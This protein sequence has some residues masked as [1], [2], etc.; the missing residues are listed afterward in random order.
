[1]A[2]DTFAGD[3]RAYAYAGIISAGPWI[4]SILCLAFLW[5][6]SYP[7]LAI[8]PQ[9]LFRVTVV[10][11]FAYSLITTGAIQLV[12][13]RF[14]ADRLYLKQK[15]IMLPTYV[16]LLLV[17]VG[18][19]GLSA[20]IFY[21]NVD[22]SLSFKIAS[23]ML[24]VA[25]SCIWQTM[26]FLSA[27]HD[28]MAIAWAFF[29][30]AV[31]SFFGALV[32]GKYWG[33]EGHLFGFTLGQIAIVVLLMYRV[34]YEFDSPVTCRF[35]FIRQIPKYYQLLLMGIFYYT[36]IWID[37]I[38]YWYSPSGDPIH[39]LFYSHYP[40][41]SC[42]FVAFLTIIPGLAHFLVDME[43]NF[44]EAYKGFY[45]AIINKGSFQTILLKK[46]EMIQTLRDSAGR[47]FVMQTAC[48]A[49]FLFLAPYFIQ[50]LSLKPEHLSTV[51]LVGIGTYFHAFLLVLFIIILYFDR[52]IEA[53]TVAIF[54]FITNAAG[55]FLVIRFAP[56]W[57]GL[58][59]TAA[60]FSTFCLA[61]FLL[62]RTVK[63]IEYLTFVEQ[64]LARRSL[65][66]ELRPL[67]KIG[68]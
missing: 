27:S 55:T 17:T 49:I 64:P 52:R 56:E 41:D 11:T 60:A 39:S 2:E 66:K 9:K 7:D 18:V 53:L 19:Q 57:M 59:Y 61:L 24:Y 62:A 45:G 30:G 32:L 29:I 58:G 51:R 63:N 44:Y 22:A 6:F 26:I 4:I 65:P 31:M 35:D 10:Y 37:K 21:A 14:L 43:T 1:M 34:F 3:I 33:L 16:G 13:T 42:C 38:I 28:Y 12:V 67:Q 68:V 46:K 50:F 40:Y 48:T 47:M 36:A 15:N 8:G 25:V 20:A 5:L 54:F 23:V